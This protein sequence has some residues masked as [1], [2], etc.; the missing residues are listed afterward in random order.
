[1]RWRGVNHV[2]FSVLEYERSVAL[3]DAM[4]GWLGYKS[5]WTLDIGYRS[6]YYMARFPMPHSYIGIQPARSG[7][8]LDHEARAVGIHHIALWARSRREVNAFHRDFLVPGDAVVTDPPQEYPVYAPGYYAVF[9]D[10]PINGIH[11]ELAHI[12]RLPGLGALR[13]FKAALW[14]AERAHPEWDG[15]PE[16]IAF[17]KLPRR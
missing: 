3:Y 16:R 14:E 10:D 11:W 4:F 7:E 15:P 9:F 13:R 2:E 1:M 17:R 12:P 8:K 6:T 5:F